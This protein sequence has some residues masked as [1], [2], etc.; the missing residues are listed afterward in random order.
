MDE[1]WFREKLQE[2]QPKLIEYES[3]QAQDLKL[4]LNL[5]YQ[6]IDVIRNSLQS[7]IYNLQEILRILD[8][9]Y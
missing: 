1:S 2:I 5:T 7:E 3:K 9:I 4:E 8:R 6:E